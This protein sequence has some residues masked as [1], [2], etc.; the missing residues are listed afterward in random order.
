MEAAAIIQLM[1]VLLPLAQKAG[2]E[3]YNLIEGLEQGKTVE[4]L[5]EE[6]VKKR[7]DLP[8]LPFE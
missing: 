6:C 2:I 8:D 5:I 1:A 4:E 7:D 3:I